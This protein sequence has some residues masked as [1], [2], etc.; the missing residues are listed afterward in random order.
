MSTKNKTT[1]TPPP[2]PERFKE[3]VKQIISVPKSEI[4]KR[5]AEWEK[6]QAAKKKRATKQGGR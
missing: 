6:Q 2:E 4:D 5:Q 3:F 1:A